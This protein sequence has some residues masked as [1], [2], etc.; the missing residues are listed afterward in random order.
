M[1][2]EVAL[3]GP[4][5][6]VERL[7]VAAHHGQF[8]AQLHEVQLMETGEGLEEW[9]WRLRH[10]QGWE[11]GKRCSHRG[12]AQYPGLAVIGYYLRANE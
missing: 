11:W 8:L 5:V 12:M 3:D 9:L 6:F 2:G 10:R 1:H 4:H 7:Q